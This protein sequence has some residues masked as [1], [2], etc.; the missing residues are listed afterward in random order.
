MLQPLVGAVSTAQAG[1]HS[2]RGGREGPP[3]PASARAQGVL[4]GLM[5][6]GAGAGATPLMS[7]TAAFKRCSYRSLQD[8]SRGSMNFL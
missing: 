4:A 3:C 8:F 7:P 5:G 1:N 6:Q 2:F